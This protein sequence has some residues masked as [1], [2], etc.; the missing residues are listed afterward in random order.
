MGVASLS[1]DNRIIYCVIWFL[2]I[3]TIK[4]TRERRITKGTSLGKQRSRTVRYLRLKATIAVLGIVLKR[5]N[6]G[7]VLGCI[8]SFSESLGWYNRLKNKTNYI[9]RFLGFLQLVTLWKHSWF[10]KGQQRSFLSLWRP[11]RP[12]SAS[13]ASKGSKTLLCWHFWN[14]SCFPNGSLTVKKT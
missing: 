5:L 4:Q 9:V 7:T 13:G 12:D 2:G 11:P 3:D 10:Q 8:N 6:L 1:Y 14:Q